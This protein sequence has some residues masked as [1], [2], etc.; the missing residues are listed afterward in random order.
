MSAPSAAGPVGQ[1]PWRRG[2]A[3]TV[4]A[5]FLAA[6]LA[7]CP[8]TQPGNPLPSQSPRPADSGHLPPLPSPA[9]ESGPKG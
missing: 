7:G 9:S 5:V 8:A 4:G 6:M 3:S 2:V 1:R